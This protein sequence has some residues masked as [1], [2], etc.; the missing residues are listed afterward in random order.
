MICP[1][2]RCALF[3]CLQLLRISL[4]LEKKS[5]PPPLPTPPMGQGIPRLGLASR[6]EINRVQGAKRKRSTCSP[7]APCSH[8]LLLP[9]HLHAPCPGLLPS[10][11][12]PLLAPGN[13]R[14]DALAPGTR[15]VCRLA[16]SR[17]PCRPRCRRPATALRTPGLT[18]C[19]PPPDSGGAWESPPSAWLRA[20]AWWCCVRTLSLHHWPNE[21]LARQGTALGWAGLGGGGRGGGSITAA[22]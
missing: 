18:F 11:H 13:H 22:R 1:D 4:F 3:S 19:A 15:P 6:G 9:A 5:L 2:L 10:T 21:L 12:P 17:L 20:A 7:L 14:R 16:R 8:A